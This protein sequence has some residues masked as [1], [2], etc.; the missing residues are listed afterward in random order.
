MGF[1]LA[2]DSSPF[3]GEREPSPGE[4]FHAPRSRSWES[5]AVVSPGTPRADGSCV[6]RAWY[7]C[8]VARDTRVASG[9]A[10]S[11]KCSVWRVGPIAPLA[12]ERSHVILF[13]HNKPIV[14]LDPY[15]KILSYRCCAVLGQILPSKF[16]RRDYLL[17]F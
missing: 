12:R 3:G 11:C 5:S 9:R 13:G 14:S 2:S 4:A 1:A 6:G 7:G 10:E 8:A 15:K 16:A 17:E